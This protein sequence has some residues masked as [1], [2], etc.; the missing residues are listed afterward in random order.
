MFQK[1]GVGTRRLTA[2]PSNLSRL[3]YNGSA[4]KSHSTTTQYRQLRKL[5]A[6]RLYELIS[7][8][9]FH[10]VDASSRAKTVNH[11]KYYI[12]KRP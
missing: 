2:P 11:I 6:V 1:K 3:Y 7:G 4:A 12:W 10:E 8:M 9:E 5:E